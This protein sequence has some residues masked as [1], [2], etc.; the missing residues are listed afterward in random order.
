MTKQGL[1]PK[2]SL[3]RTHLDIG[4]Q[5]TNPHP[6][7]WSSPSQHEGG[8]TKYPCSLLVTSWTIGV[9]F[10]TW[11]GPFLSATT[12]KSVLR[13]TYWVP[14]ALC[15]LKVIT[16]L[17]PV[18]MNERNLPSHLPIFTAYTILRGEAWAQGH[19]MKRFSIVAYLSYEGGT[20]LS[21]TVSVVCRQYRLVPFQEDILPP[22]PEGQ[23]RKT[24][25]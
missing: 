1:V 20:K 6:N 25:H 10:P 14:G 11:T 5:F 13:P 9:R 3:D 8:G 15:S 23:Q 17:H 16:E 22:S 4:A 12:T 19:L 21:H 18:R 24:K 2:W 7:T